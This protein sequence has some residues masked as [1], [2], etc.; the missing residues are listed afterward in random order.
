[1]KAKEHTKL[2]IKAKPVIPKS[3]PKLERKMKK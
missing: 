3:I 2:A 1:M